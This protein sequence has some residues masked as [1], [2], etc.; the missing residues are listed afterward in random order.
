MEPSLPTLRAR[1]A[2]PRDTQ[3]L[4]AATRKGNQIYVRTFNSQGLPRIDPLLVSSGDDIPRL[5]PISCQNGN[6][7]LVSW[8][9]S[10][11]PGNGFDVYGT[12]LDIDKIT[13]VGDMKPDAPSSF[14]LFQNYPKGYVTND[15]ELRA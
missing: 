14:T 8:S 2:V 15:A 7:L 3:G 4:Q 10:R 12:M 1:P 13:S 6:K 11:T 5:D 9:E